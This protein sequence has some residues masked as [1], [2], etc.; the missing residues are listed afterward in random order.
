MSHYENIFDLTDRL[1]ITWM[2]FLSH[3]RTTL[4]GL[5]V[6]ERLRQLTTL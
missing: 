2:F 5:I 3:Y 1:G 4:Y 6:T